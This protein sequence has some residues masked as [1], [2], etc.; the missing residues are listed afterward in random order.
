[1]PSPY[2][3]L[4]TVN[5]HDVVKALA[6]LMGPLVNTDHGRLIGT[7]KP[8]ETFV[9]LARFSPADRLTLTR[10]A[11]RLGSGKSGAF[12]AGLDDKH[13][14]AFICRKFMNTEHGLPCFE[15]LM[16]G[17]SLFT[18]MPI[19]R[20]TTENLD[21]VIDAVLKEDETQFIDRAD[22]I[23]QQ[24]ARF[25]SGSGIGPE[26]EGSPYARLRSIGIIPG[27]RPTVKVA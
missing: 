3:S 18:D 27:R 23:H 7:S 9:L 11:L 12:L 25:F 10:C 5:T 24:I 26:D 21:Y 13:I 17:L 6:H 1:M 2:E 14:M 22:A 16:L 19:T 20:N 8:H 4:S 15:G